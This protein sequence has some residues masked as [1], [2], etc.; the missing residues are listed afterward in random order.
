M[1]K[2]WFHESNCFLARYKVDPNRRQEFLSALD[3]MFESTQPWYDE[4]AHFAFHGWARDPDTWI[5]IA[6]W[7]NE[8][9]LKRLREDPEWQKHS[10]RMLECCTEPM[11]I[12]HFSGMKVDRGV[13][14]L[15]PAGESG[16]HPSSSS[17][18]VICI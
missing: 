3:D 12:E 5:V 10:V 6:S 14:N 9:I 18:G 11:V 15:Y 2:A 8:E 1:T 13:F 4:H 7:K 16:V 17:L